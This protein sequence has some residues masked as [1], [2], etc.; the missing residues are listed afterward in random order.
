M[1]ATALAVVSIAACTSI[2]GTLTWNKG[3]IVVPS[4]IIGKQ[5]NPITLQ[6]EIKLQV[7]LETERG[8]IAVGRLTYGKVSIVG[9]KV[10][11]PYLVEALP[12]PTF[13]TYTGTP[14]EAFDF[15]SHPRP[16][17]FF[18]RGPYN[19]NNDFAIL[20]GGYRQILAMN[21]VTVTSNDPVTGADLNYWK[22][23]KVA[24]KSVPNVTIATLASGKKQPKKSKPETAH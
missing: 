20:P 9:Q 16:G 21:Q 24:A 2:S 5:G 19:P 1:F 10:S 13:S 23:W 11:V 8:L 7:Y 22:D 14:L 18:L 15:R 6:D 12:L 3:D 17:G 4:P